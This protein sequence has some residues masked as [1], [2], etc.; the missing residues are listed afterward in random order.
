MN[1]IL[2]SSHALASNYN[3]FPSIHAVGCTTTKLMMEI[4]N[5][6]FPAN[7][8]AQSFVKED[9]HKYSHYVS[10]LLLHLP[11]AE[12]QK[13]IKTYYKFVVLRDPIVRILSAYI[14]KVSMDQTLLLYSQSVYLRT[15]DLYSVDICR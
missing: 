8:S 9:A 11:V 5:G 7:I 13:R 10:S 3:N 15:V 14:D 2:S 1:I 4:M 12:R 6:E